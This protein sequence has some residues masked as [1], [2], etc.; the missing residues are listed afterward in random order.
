VSMAVTVQA[1]RVVQVVVPLTD[2]ECRCRRDKRGP[3]KFAVAA[4]LSEFQQSLYAHSRLGQYLSEGT[5]ANLLV[6]GHHDAGGR[7]RAF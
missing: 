1:T 7:V 4:D 2:S 6:I 5:G 3:A